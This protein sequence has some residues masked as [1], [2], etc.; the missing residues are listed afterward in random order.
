MSTFTRS[1]SASTVESGIPWQITSL[2]DVQIDFGN[3]T[4]L[5]C[6]R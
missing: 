1:P 4:E 2:T 5:G 6:G 3:S